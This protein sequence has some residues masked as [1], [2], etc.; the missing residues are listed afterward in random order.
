M[1]YPYQTSPF[2]SVEFAFLESTDCQEVTQ[3][4]V[5][6]QSSSIDH[7]RDE[8]TLDLTF[9]FTRLVPPTSGGIQIPD[10]SADRFD[11][12]SFGESSEV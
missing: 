8:T 10:T 2:A 9:D 3:V 4:N 7:D 12:D 5:I 1:L 11:R 6:V